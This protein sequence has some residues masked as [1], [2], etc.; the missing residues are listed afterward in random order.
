MTNLEID[1][2]AQRRQLLARRMDLRA[3]QA[4]VEHDRGHSDEPLAADFAEQ[5]LQTRNDDVLEGIDQA[6]LAEI[7]EI[8]AALARIENGRY[9]TC[10]RCGATI[11]PQ[12][13]L[14]MPQAVTCVS[15]S[16]KSTTW[17]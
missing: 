9:G 2:Q 15:C 7:T 1:L 10:A 14:A 13:L 5:A 3:R 17:R 4:R 16:S 12:R 8:D 6:A 11:A